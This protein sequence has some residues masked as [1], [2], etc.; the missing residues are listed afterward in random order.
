MPALAKVEAFVENVEA[1]EK[2]IEVFEAVVEILEEKVG[3]FEEKVESCS[4]KPQP[5]IL[6]TA[7]IVR[8]LQAKVAHFGIGGW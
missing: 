3:G 4:P 5:Q 1:L 2:N 7:R 8:E 6:H